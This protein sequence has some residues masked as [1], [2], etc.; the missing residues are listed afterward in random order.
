MPIKSCALPGGGRGFQWGDNGK[1]YPTRVQAE[2]QAEAAHAN[3]YTG[4]VMAL[5]KSA[6][7]I[8]ADGQLHVSQTNISKANICPY[9]GHEIPNYEKLGLMP[10]RVYQMYRHPDELKKGAHT[11]N[12]KQLMLGHFIVSAREPKLDRVCGAIGTDAQFVDPYLKAS[13]T[14]WDHEVIEMIEAGETEE[15]SCGYQYVADMTPGA[16]NGLTY[17]GIM[18]SIVANHVALV[19]EGRAG[20]DV[21]VADAKLGKPSMIT[22]KKALMVQGAARAF[23]ASIACDAKIDLRP[24]LDGVTAKTFKA[25][26]AAVVARIAKDAKL[27]DDSMAGLKIVLDAME[28]EEVDGEDEWEPEENAE[29]EEEMTEAEKAKAAKD[30]K[31]RDKAAK[32]KA[33]RDKAAKDKDMD[34]RAE[35]ESEEDKETEEQTKAKDKKAMDAAIAKVRADTIAEMNAIAAAKADVEPIVGHITAAMDSAEAVYDFAL[36]HLGEDKTGLNLAGK[37]RLV[38]A[39]GSKA[40]APT[41]ATDSKARANVADMFPQL[42]RIR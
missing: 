28:T 41:F 15:I 30:K 40:V 31:A 42:A 1:C 36:D 16:H 35:D 4:D 33:A 22:S 5:D 8:D 37:R 3:G 39:L 6:R 14:V 24:A 21:V 27:D 25:K 26:K 7:R 32:D 20:P 18:R 11:F 34:A 13:I 19:P 12:G 2:R 23:L 9:Y 29:D 10:D 38:S 17:D